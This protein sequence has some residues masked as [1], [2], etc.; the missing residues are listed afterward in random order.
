MIPS[1]ILPIHRF[2]LHIG[3]ETVTRSPYR[4]MLLSRN[5]FGR[6]RVP[7]YRHRAR[8]ISA[9]GLGDRK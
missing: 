9:L 4:D 2:I 6:D 7:V 3:L 5:N 1:Y 8:P